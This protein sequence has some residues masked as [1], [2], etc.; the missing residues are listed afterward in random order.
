MTHRR[1]ELSPSSGGRIAIVVS[2]TNDFVTEKLLDGALGELG[3]A[4]EIVIIDVAGAF[5]VISATRKAFDAGYHGVIAIGAVIRG[6]TPHFEYI[7]N[8]V[9]NGL[10]AISAEGHAIAFGILT[11]DS[12]TQA[13]ERAG[14]ALGNK[15]QEA[16][17]ALLQL[18]SAAQ[19]LATEPV[20]AS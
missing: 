5:E 18:L 11:V 2:R 6:D 1:L 17:L 15:G 19:R 20:R 9:T 13:A 8:A 4:D 16:A 10:A 14:G 7:S 3:G 12:A